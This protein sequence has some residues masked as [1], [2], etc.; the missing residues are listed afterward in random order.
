MHRDSQ[1]VL[2]A[3][4]AGLACAYALTRAGVPVTVIERDERVG[5]LAKTIAHD[6]WLLDL[7]P[8][9]FFTKIDK[10]NALWEEVL[11]EEQV[12]VDR[13]TRIYYGGRY[14][15]YPLKAWEALLTL[16]V[17]ETARILASYAAA[18]L[19]P[20]PH[21]R[22]FE[23][24]TINQF[25][26]R[27]YE[28][29]FK[30]YTE[31]LWG[32]PCT[33]ISPDWA[34]QRIKGLSLS[35]AIRGALLGGRGDVKSLVDRFQY[36]R[37]GAGQLYERM[38]AALAG[39]A[40]PVRLGWE[41]VAIHHDQGRVT[42]VTVRRRGASETERLDTAGVVS[43]IPLPLLLRQLDPPPPA[44]VLAAAGSLRFRN[45]LLAYL[46][47]EGASLFPDNWLY[48][49]DPSVRIGR[50]TNFANWSPAMV[51]RTDRTPLCAELWCFA[52][53]ALWQAPEAE[54]LALAER[55]L[56][57]IGLL[58][59]EPVVE[60][61]LVRLPNVYPV[62]TGDYLEAIDLVR[63]YL[64]G[65]AGLQLIGRY[66]TFK[67]NN[68]D[69]SLLMGL[70]AAENVSAGAGHDLWSVNADDEYHEEVRV[71]PASQPTP[72]G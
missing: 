7:G 32:I 58:G 50:V 62:Y 45:T 6:G 26:R 19:A 40:H 49:N 22:S 14:F 41:T 36:P 5:G 56:R 11:G 25:G 70:L 39:A 67:Y 17:G 47:V 52:D 15:H 8:H 66:G 38:A 21:P 54:V 68:Q 24:W 29:F 31:K 37:L 43:S 28:I 3:G 35:S 10:V 46:F 64:T 20:D 18:R 72:V 61:F 12:T 44:E 16:G 63:R 42:G 57:E 65:I 48:I 30:G 23:A 71:A 27:L 51:P 1:I 4:P 69:H 33:A 2:G 9:R 59:Q 60:G 13:L 34:A 55:E 53:E